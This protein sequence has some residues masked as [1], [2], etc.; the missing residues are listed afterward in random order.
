MLQF[1]QTMPQAAELVMDLLVKNF[2]WPGAEELA[3]RFRKVAVAQGIVE[4]DPEKGEQPPPPPPPNPDMVKAETEAAKAEAGIAKPEA[5]TDGQEL[6]NAKSAVELM[7][8]GGALPIGRRSGQ[9]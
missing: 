2:D 7:L 6:E 8:A 1:M 3:D 5:E 9:G 4:P